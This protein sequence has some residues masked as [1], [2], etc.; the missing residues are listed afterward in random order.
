MSGVKFYGNCQHISHSNGMPCVSP[1]VQH[2][3]LVQE[4]EKRSLQLFCGENG[5]FGHF[6]YFSSQVVFKVAATSWVVQ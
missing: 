4:R 5:Q 1:S 6:R 2:Q 3:E